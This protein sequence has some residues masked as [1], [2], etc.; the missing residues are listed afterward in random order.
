MQSAYQAYLDGTI[1]SS[2]PGLPEFLA[3]I[4]MCPWAFGI[5]PDE[6]RPNWLHLEP[7]APVT[8][9]HV[10]PRMR[11]FWE[12]MRQLLQTAALL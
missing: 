5:S 2:H 7:P 3:I 1:N 12:R 8:N 6:D 11:T 9:E 10:A 4:E